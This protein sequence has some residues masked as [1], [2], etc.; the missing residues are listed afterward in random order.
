MGKAYCWNC[1]TRHNAPTGKYCLVKPVE[2]DKFVDMQEEMAPPPAVAGSSKTPDGSYDIH[3]PATSSSDDLA[4]RMD[5]LETLI[6]KLSEGLSGEHESEFDHSSTTSA[7]RSPSP[8][9]DRH[10]KAPSQRY[11]SPSKSDE[12]SYDTLFESEDVQVQ[13]F[14]QV[15]VATFRT[16]M[17][18]YENGQDITGLLRH[19]R[20]MA[21]KSA[22]EVYVME[23]F[24][25]YDKYVRNVAGRKGIK[26]FGRVHDIDKSRFFNLENYKEVRALKAKP[27]KAKK[28]GP[29]YRFNSN[30]GCTSRGCVYTHKCSSCDQMGHS[31]GECKAS[32]RSSSSK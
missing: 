8:R 10:G 22:A 9:R 31:L 18:L 7:D 6:Y 30:K 17:A 24:V 20:F 19:G 3:L 11:M 23:T 21:E 32:T 2:E 5:G 29:C 12:F 16:L 13:T 1:S 28:S 27:P 15:M 14:S 4:R 25:Q 26:A